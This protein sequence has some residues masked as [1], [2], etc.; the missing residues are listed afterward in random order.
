MARVSWEFSSIPYFSATAVEEL[1]TRNPVEFTLLEGQPEFTEYKVNNME[2]K[3]VFRKKYG[4]PRLVQFH[5]FQLAYSKVSKDVIDVFN[6]YMRFF[7]Q[8]IYIK[9]WQFDAK[10]DSILAT[11]SGAVDCV[12]VGNGTYYEYF[13]PYRNLAD[14]EAALTK[15]WK[16]G[17]LQSTGYTIDYE[18]GSVTFTTQLSST[19]R[20]SMHFVWRPKVSVLNLDP[21]PIVGQRF[22]KPKYTPV[23]ILKEV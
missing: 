12:P 10:Y 6:N 14:D 7:G 23:I 1:F 15:V 21:R 8:T 22:D 3:T 19:D 4:D 11:E 5:K 20:V 16:N 18:E 17:V 2:D 9:L 13:T